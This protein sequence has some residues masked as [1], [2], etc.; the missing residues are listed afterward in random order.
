MRIMLDPGHQGARPGMD[1]GAVGNSLVEATLNLQTAQA[2]AEAL[3]AKCHG[4]VDKLGDQVEVYFTRT[5]DEALT[6]AE[7]LRRIARINPDICISVHYD[8]FTG[9]AARGSSVFHSVRTERD[10]ELAK[11]ISVRLA[12]TGMPSRGIRTRATSAGEDYY[13]IIREVL[14]HDTIALLVECAFISSPDDA[15]L[16]KAGWIK[17]AGEAIAGAVYEH[18]QPQLQPADAG[19]VVYVAGQ[20]YPATMRSGSMWCPGR[21]PLEALGCLV[22]WDAENQLMVVIPPELRRAAGSTGPAV[23]IVQPRVVYETALE[24]GQTLIPVR[25]TFQALG[26][27][28]IYDGRTQTATVK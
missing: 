14:D 15:Q 12:Q 26:L 28:V 18:I 7:R 22:V 16:I 5:S 19:P 13:Y 10:D 8:S 21:A 23:A 25:A 4:L 20:S 1:T 2:I 9:P 3:Q 27:Q 17:Q 24:G 6:Q 11:L